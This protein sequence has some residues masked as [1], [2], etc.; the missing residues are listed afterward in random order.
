MFST[1]FRIF[2]YVSGN[3]GISALKETVQGVSKKAIQL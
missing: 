3:I 2:D 1:D